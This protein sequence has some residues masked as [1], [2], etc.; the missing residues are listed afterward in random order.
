V[1]VTHTWGTVLATQLYGSG[2]KSI[3]YTFHQDITTISV[4]LLGF[5]CFL[6]YRLTGK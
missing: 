6:T 1:F 5:T 3:L 4:T 2:K